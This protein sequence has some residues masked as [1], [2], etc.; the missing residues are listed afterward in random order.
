MRPVLKNAWP[1]ENGAP[2]NYNPHGKA[3]HDLESNLGYYCSYCEVFSSDL[4]VE[5]IISRD[6]NSGLSHNWDNF[7]VACGRCNGR[8]NKT[9]KAVDL[10]ITH[11]PHQNNT[12]KSFIYK[13]GGLVKINPVLSGDSII[14]ANN[15]MNLV[16]LDKYPGN[17]K[18]PDLKN[19]TRWDH[20][21][22]A[23]EW[24]KKR[25]SDYESG[26]LTAAQV[27][28]FATLRGFFSIWYSVFALHPAVRQLL[29]TEF[30][31]TAGV[32]F[33]AADN[34]NPI[35]RNPANLGDPI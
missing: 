29:I 14:H 26:R 3:K 5:H 18:Y 17:P 7:L 35:D 12:Y 22:Q 15:L 4:E 13:E 27:V 11:F 20:R 25:L 21:R 34:Y 1:D 23:W 10:S 28:E 9:N 30:A 6:Q 24:A 16:G 8:D 31:G 2:K 32:C 33:D 19:D